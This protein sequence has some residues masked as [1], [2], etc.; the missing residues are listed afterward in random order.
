MKQCLLLLSVAVLVC[1]RAPAQFVPTPQGPDSIAA[2]QDSTSL[3]LVKSGSDSTLSAT[4]SA[5]VQE[6]HPQDSPVNRGFLIRTTDGHAELRI[7]GSVRLNGII[8]F[9]GLQSQATFNTYEIPVGEASSNEVRYQMYGGQTRLGLEATH[10]ASFGDIFTRVETDFLGA[11]NTLRLR[12]AHASV[13]RFLFGHTWSTFADLTAIPLTVDLDGPN[14]S[15]S[16]R[17]VQI[18][19]S[20]HLTEGMSWD[21]S[22]E[23]PNLEITIS[24]SLQT[25]STFQSFPDVIG[26]LRRSGEWGHIQVAGV[27][28]SISTNASGLTHNEAARVGY[29]L[30]VSGRIYLG[31]E[32]PHR[33]LFQLVGGRAISRYISTLARKGLDVVYDPV[34]GS[35]N[36]IP[37]F[38]GYLS[39]A[40]QWASSLLSYVTVGFVRL[41]NVEAQSGDSFRFSRYISGNVFWDV[42]PGTRLGAEYS[43]GLRENKDRSHGTASRISFILMYDF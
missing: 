17:T 5:R 4:D 7:R 13:Y 12:H 21:V 16:E 10:K 27:I 33:M 36:L 9:K 3:L 6:A 41:G 20:S 28:R 32:K 14:G 34:T 24:D 39:Y 19:Y 25:E 11:S 1:W 29:G 26:R 22:I 38:G 40:R 15:V 18:R 31:G 2:P 37:T 35:I 43:W 42:A 23:S 8:D 30:L